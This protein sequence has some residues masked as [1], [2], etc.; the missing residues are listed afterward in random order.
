VGK[1]TTVMMKIDRKQ[2]PPSPRAETDP[3]PVTSRNREAKKG[4][5]GRQVSFINRGWRLGIQLYIL[6]K[7]K[8]VALEPVAFPGE[9]RIGKLDHKR[10]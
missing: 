1:K 10:G 5:S 8:G 9:C 2:S 4:T 6:E 7:R 3:V